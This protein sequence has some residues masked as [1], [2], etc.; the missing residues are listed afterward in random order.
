MSEFW[1]K[2]GSGPIR[3]P[4]GAE[5]GVVHWVGTVESSSGPW[6]AWRPVTLTDGSRAWLKMVRRKET[7]ELGV[8]GVRISYDPP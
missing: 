6:F 3:D 7:R 2:S 4:S 5:I 8:A 1:V